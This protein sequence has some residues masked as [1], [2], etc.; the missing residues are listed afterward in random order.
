MYRTV[1]KR[2]YGSGGIVPILHVPYRKNRWDSRISLT[3]TV[4]FRKILL[5]VPH[6]FL[7]VPYRIE[8]VPRGR[9]AR[10]APVYVPRLH[11]HPHSD[12]FR[13]GTTDKLAKKTLA[14]NPIAPA[15]NPGTSGTE[16]KKPIDPSLKIMEMRKS[17]VF[18]RLSVVSHL[19]YLD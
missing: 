13:Y 3:C 19:F 17:K 14:K 5:Y 7:H 8:K 15:Q 18:A 16:Q 11:P 12:W 2:I 6:T 1:T 4:P 10:S 9:C